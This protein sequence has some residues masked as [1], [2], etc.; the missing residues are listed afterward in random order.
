MNSKAIAPSFKRVGFLARW[1]QDATLPKPLREHGLGTAIRAESSSTH[2]QLETG[3][4][5]ENVNVELDVVSDQLIRRVNKKQ[6]SLQI[7]SFVGVLMTGI[8]VNG[9]DTVQMS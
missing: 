3:P 6:P 1:I 5:L 8:C 7:L 4:R 2:V 9:A